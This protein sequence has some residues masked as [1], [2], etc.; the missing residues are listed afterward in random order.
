MARRPGRH[1]YLRGG[2]CSKV[3]APPQP[4]NPAH[5]ATWPR[6]RAAIYPPIS[7]DAQPCR[8]H[9]PTN[10]DPTCTTPRGS[11][12]TAMRTTTRCAR[13]PRRSRVW[14]RRRRPC[15]EEGARV[16]GEPM[17]KSMYTHNAHMCAML[18]YN[19]G[20]HASDN[21]A[22]RIHKYLGQPRKR[23]TNAGAHGNKG[24][25]GAGPLR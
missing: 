14:R 25:A 17:P 2:W 22:H 24:G 19:T 1:R 23:T 11:D 20:A 21:P 15:A 12:W 10:T 13:W 16:A 8:A 3:G 5:E 9:S 7:C 4:L 18:R 6:K